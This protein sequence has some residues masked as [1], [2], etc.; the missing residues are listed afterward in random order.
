MK[1]AEPRI[2]V[3]CEASYAA[4]ILHGAWIDLYGLDAEDI[5]KEVQEMLKASTIPYAEE[6]RIDD[7]DNMGGY[8][9]C[10]LEEA[11]AITE[12]IEQTDSLAVIYWLESGCGQG[13]APYEYL[14][15]FEEAYWGCFK[16]EED[17]AT[18]YLED[19]GTQDELENVSI[20]DCNAWF[21]LDMK[22]VASDL[23]INTFWSHQTGY[24]TV[25]IFSRN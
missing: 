7:T 15:K 21:Y 5:E 22:Q 3:A 9:P 23:F 1:Q 17:F 10:D 24:E 20:L 13:L 14:K 12:I 16:S 25:H 19:I 2:Y 4:G 11:S 6:W 8:I 18:Q